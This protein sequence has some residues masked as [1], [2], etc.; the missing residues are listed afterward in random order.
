MRSGD[1]RRSVGLEKC[2][3]AQVNK[4]IKARYKAQTLETPYKPAK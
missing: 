4:K 2:H 1:E 3:M